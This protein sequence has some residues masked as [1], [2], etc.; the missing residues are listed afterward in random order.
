MFKFYK[1]QLRLNF[2][3]KNFLTKNLY[4]EKSQKAQLLNIIIFMQHKIRQ[5]F[6]W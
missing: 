6:S 3:I 1:K 2:L 4:D 5:K